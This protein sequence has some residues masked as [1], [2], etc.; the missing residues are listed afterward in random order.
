MAGLTGPPD[1]EPVRV[2]ISYAHDSDE[3]VAAVRDLWVFLRGQGI[4]ARLDLPAAERRQDWPAWMAEQVRDARFV[5]VVASPA[6]KRRSEGQAAADEGRGVQFEARLIREYFYR[7]QQ[8]GMERF[9]PVLLP[10]VP[11]ECIPDF[12]LPTSATSYQVSSASVAGSEALL[13]ALTGQPYEVEPPL[14][15]VPVLRPR[16][17]GRVGEG[18]GGAGA[19]LRN[20]LVLAVSLASGMVSCRA[21]LAGTMLGEQAAPVPYRIEDVW[22]AL[23]VTGAEER[24]AEAGHRL[25]EAL[26]G[27]EAARHVTDLVDHAALGSVLEVVVEAD[28]SAAWLPFELLRLPDGR[29][30]ATLPMVWMRRRLPVAGRAAT[31]PLPGPLKILVAVAA[32]DETRCGRSANSLGCRSRNSAPGPRCR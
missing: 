8:A 16:P 30:L 11:A 18:L 9:L 2:F 20:E 26:L 22:D 5:L 23:E 12:L 10:G 28:A 27:E 4:D 14:G 29:V 31:G 1:E 25:R 7:D 17:P 13:R 24:L 15:R 3:H 19:G 21:V 32:P 6:Y